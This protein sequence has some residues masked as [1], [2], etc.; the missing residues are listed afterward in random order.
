MYL[1][2]IIWL[3]TIALA[4]YLSYFDPQSEARERKQIRQRFNPVRKPITPTE[5]H[6]EPQ[7]D[8][9][10]KNARSV[11]AETIARQERIKKRMALEKEQ[12]EKIKLEINQ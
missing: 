10:N 6:M 1:P 12:M 5:P 3:L 8:V 2:A 9:N 11:D 7:R 4:E